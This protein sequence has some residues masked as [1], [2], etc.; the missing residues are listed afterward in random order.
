MVLRSA[1]RT[2]QTRSEISGVGNQPENPIWQN[3]C[4][5]RAVSTATSK[6][7]ALDA[8]LTY[9]RIGVVGIHDSARPRKVSAC[10]FK[11]G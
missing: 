11:R 4:E 10:V 5:P 9:L 2:I 7:A 8:A 3:V 6:M 1:L